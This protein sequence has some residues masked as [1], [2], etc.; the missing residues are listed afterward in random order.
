MALELSS[1][2]RSTKQ[3][4]IL[5]STTLQNGATATGNGTTAIPKGYPATILVSGITTATVL[6]E[7]SPD[8]G[9]TWVSTGLTVTADGMLTILGPHKLIRARISA[10]TS[11]TIYVYLV[12]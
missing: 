2:A 5:S 12:E 4:S 3:R 1:S 11:G 7:S 10:Y 8:G 9:T 6:V